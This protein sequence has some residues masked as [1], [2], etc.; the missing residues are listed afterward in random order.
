VGGDCTLGMLN[1]G[2]RFKGSD[3]AA[4]SAMFVMA[5]IPPAWS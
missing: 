1:I 5:Y 2:Q 3:L 4:A